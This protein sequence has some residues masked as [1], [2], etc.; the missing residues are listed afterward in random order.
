MAEYPNNGYAAYIKRH[1][2]PIWLRRKL[3]SAFFEHMAILS[4]FVVDFAREGF[5]SHLIDR[6]PPDALPE[7]ARD[8][9]LERWPTET[10]EQ[11]RAR[12]G[13]AWGVWEFGGTNKGVLDAVQGLGYF[14][15]VI[16]EYWDWPDGNDAAWARFWIV[17]DQPHPIQAPPPIGG[18][19][20][21][22][23]TIVGV[24]GITDDDV[25][26]LRRIVRTWKAAHA[27]CEK[28]IAVVSGIYVGGFTVG[29]SIVIGGETVEITLEG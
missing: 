1:P 22:D 3:G 11:H 4:D 14:D 23:G 18:F 25:E 2:I 10:E 26:R 5:K 9:T 7:H 27:H 16:Y 29:N 19:T 8:R 13:N 20:V 15:S 21:G 12:I 28:I 24:G 6:C 17:I